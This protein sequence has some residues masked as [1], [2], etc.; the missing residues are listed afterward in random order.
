ML[1]MFLDTLALFGGAVL[2][3]VAVWFICFV[4]EVVFRCWLKRKKFGR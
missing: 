3:I 2:I 4:G 1:D